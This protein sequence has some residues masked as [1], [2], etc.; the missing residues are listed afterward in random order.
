M[1]EEGHDLQKKSICS[2]SWFANSNLTL[3]ESLKL[4]YMWAHHHMQ[5]EAQHEARV[6]KNAT[7]RSYY[8]HRK[9]C[10]GWLLS[11]ED[12]IGGKGQ[13]VEIDESKSR[14]QKD[15]CGHRA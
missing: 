13:I 2:G 11:K 12:R 10:V 7:V 9:A 14:K 15:H 6:G 8:E 3:A 4:S 5:E 1:C